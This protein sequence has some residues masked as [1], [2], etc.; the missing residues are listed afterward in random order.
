MSFEDQVLSLPR[1]IDFIYY[2]SCSG[3]E[4]FTSLI[5]LSC[6]LTR[7]LLKHNDVVLNELR[8]IYDSPVYFKRK[9]NSFLEYI[10]YTGH[11]MTSEEIIR[12]CKSSIFSS[13]LHHYASELK[14]F[15][16]DLSIYSLVEV[17]NTESIVIKRLERIYKK[18]IIVACKHFNYMNVNKLNDFNSTKYW[19]VLNIDPITKEGQ[20]CVYNSAK[21][22][23]KNDNLNFRTVSNNIERFPFF[24]YMIYE[25]YDE[26]KYF[27]ENRYGSNL[28]FD[29]IDRSLKDYYQIRVKPYLK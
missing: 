3:G 29:F 14:N 4:F 25:D 17:W 18:T 5:A 13:M 12:N 1:K 19:D 16:G 23:F 10:D 15:K 26:V 6:P 20:R 2:G 11:M 27:L 28:D 24:D 9:I 21:Q 8:P 22:I 7:H